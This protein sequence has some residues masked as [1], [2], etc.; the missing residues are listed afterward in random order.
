[1]ETEAQCEVGQRCTRCQCEPGQ[2]GSTTTTTLPGLQASDFMMFSGVETA[3]PLEVM[4]DTCGGDDCMPVTSPVRTG[5][6]AC[7]IAMDTFTGLRPCRAFAVSEIFARVYHRIDVVTPPA[8]ETFAPVIVFDARV[9]TGV[10]EVDVGVQPDGMIRYRLRDRLL[11]QDLGFSE[12]LPAGEWV[13]VELG[14][15]M[16]AGTGSAEMRLNGQT[17]AQ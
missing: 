17:V 11:E 13:E 16:G 2:G 14:T 6:Y 5:T 7:Q 12:V 15:H 10:T 8:T 3:D 4:D 9:P 1:C